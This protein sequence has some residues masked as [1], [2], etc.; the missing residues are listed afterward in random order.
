MGV[1]LTWSCCGALGVGGSLSAGDGGE[2]SHGRPQREHPGGERGE[3][4]LWDCNGVGHGSEPQRGPR[5][6]KTPS[7]SCLKSHPQQ[8]P[9]AE[10]HQPGGGRKPRCY[11]S[12]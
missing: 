9:T 11:G 3:H 7:Y 8:Q 6:P 10:C 1:T 5:G 4:P 12:P 2:R